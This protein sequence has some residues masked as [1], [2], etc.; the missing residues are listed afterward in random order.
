MPISE[1]RNFL[2]R[3]LRI[4]ASLEGPHLSPNQL[5][6]NIVDVNTFDCLVDCYWVLLPMRFQQHLHTFGCQVGGTL[7]SVGNGVQAILAHLFVA[8]PSPKYSLEITIVRMNVYHAVHLLYISS[9]NDGRKTETKQ[10]ID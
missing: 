10:N 7:G 1:G 9:D 2:R 5:R 3:T 8:G 6:Y 4:A